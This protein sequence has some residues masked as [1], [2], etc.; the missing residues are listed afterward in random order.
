[1]IRIIRPE[2]YSE[3]SL[4]RQ[5]VVYDFIAYEEDYNLERVLEWDHRF[6]RFTDGERRMFEEM[7]MDHASLIF[8][9]Y[10]LNN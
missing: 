10:P 4:V 1:M 8:G 2:M 5:K 6:L 9:E 3:Y 7:Y